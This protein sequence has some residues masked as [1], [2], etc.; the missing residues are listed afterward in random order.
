M[1][2]DFNSIEELFAN[3]TNDFIKVMKNEVTE[4]FKDK[5]QE[6]IEEVVYNVYDPI[7]Y[8]RRYENDGLLDR[9]NMKSKVTKKGDLIELE[10]TNETTVS[11]YTYDS[12]RGDRLD[13]IIEHGTGGV[14]EYS[15]PRPF[16]EETQKRVDSN[17]ILEKCL[18]SKLDY[19]K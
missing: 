16:M 1:S 8:L 7:N 19:L 12:N 5:H 11:P 13:E 2:R 14:Y 3:V 15:Q 4:E 10:F 6:V 18:K 9:D 17:R